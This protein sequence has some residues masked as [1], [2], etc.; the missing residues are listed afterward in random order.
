MLHVNLQH[1]AADAASPPNSAAAVSSYEDGQPMS[2]G[3][4][5]QVLLMGNAYSP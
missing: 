3:D 5:V 2:T 4:M 1:P